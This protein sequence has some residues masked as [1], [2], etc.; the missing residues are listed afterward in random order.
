[1]HAS[2]R[3]ARQ[4]SAILLWS[5]LAA[6]L[7]QSAIGF[8][9]SRYLKRTLG[10]APEV[11]VRLLTLGAYL[12]AGEGVWHDVRLAW[13]G[14]RIEFPGTLRVEEAELG[15]PL[16]PLIRVEKA[17]LSQIWTL[18]T[19]TVDAA[20]ISPLRPEWRLLKGPPGAPSSWVPKVPLNLEVSDLKVELAVT[21]LHGSLS[22][23]GREG[24]AAGVW[25]VAL[26]DPEGALAEGSGRWSGE[27]CM[28]EFRLSAAKRESIQGSLTWTNDRFTLRSEA[29]EG[30][31]VWLLD[32]QGTRGA[33]ARFV[34]WHSAPGVRPRMAVAGIRIPEPGGKGGLVIK[35]LGGDVPL[36]PL[37]VGQLGRLDDLLLRLDSTPADPNDPVRVACVSVDV[38]GRLVGPAGRFRG[39]VVAVLRQLGQGTTDLSMEGRAGKEEAGPGEDP[40][41]APALTCAVQGEWKESGDTSFSAKFQTGGG[42]LGVSV[43]RKG[44]L[45]M[46]EGQLAIGKGRLT[47]NGT[48]RGEEWRVAGQGRIAP[49]DPASAPFPLPPGPLEGRFSAE[50]RGAAWESADFTFRGRG[51]WQ[52]RLTG[53]LW[54]ATVRD[55]E[56]TGHGM[57]VKGIQ[58][59]L[60]GKTAEGSPGLAS[61]RAKLDAADVS[62]GTGGQD[63]RLSLQGSGSRS[64]HEWRVGAVL[65]FLDGQASCRIVGT[66]LLSGSYKVEGGDVSLLGGALK[67]DGVGASLHPFDAS[68]LDHWSGASA[69][70][71]GEPMAGVKGDLHFDGATDTFKM[72]GRCPHWGGEVSALLTLSSREQ[73]SVD[74][75]VQDVQAAPVPA[76]VRNWVDLPLSL[77]DGTISGGVLLPLPDVVQGLGLDLRFRDATV[78][79]GEGGHAFR[80]AD[81]AL[82]A[83]LRAGVFEAAPQPWTLD[84]GR[85]ALDMGLGVRNGATEVS[86][87]TARAPLGRLQSALTDFLPEYLVFGKVDGEGAVEGKAVIDRDGPFIQGQLTLFAAGFLSEDKSLRFKG[88]TGRLPLVIHL[89][90]ATQA[91]P[92]YPSVIP[93]SFAQTFDALAPK[94]GEPPP[95]HLERVRYSVFT[96]DDLD[97]YPRAAEGN[98]VLALAGGRIWEGLLRGEVGLSLGEDGLRYAGQVLLK[99]ASLSAF[100]EQSGAL[101]GFLSGNASAGIT[102]A[103]E[104]AGVAD[105]RALGEVWVDPAGKEERVIARE[106][107]I[108]MGG[109]Q[110]KRI[111][112][113]DTLAYDV[114]RLRCGLDQG[115]LTVY[116]LQLSHEANPVLALV[117]KDVSFEV[118]V[119]QR[120]SISVWQLINHI[121]GLVQRPEATGPVG[122]PKE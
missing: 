2:F 37:P 91:V 105:L 110:V 26:R 84:G 14:A 58:A 101:R 74:I 42:G 77:P 68:A 23:W 20:T 10:T 75:H 96:L 15:P 32:G 1:M 57:A 100:C 119:P 108:K 34:L 93:A 52:A 7:I 95:L 46:H 69:T 41:G 61:W 17:N 116:S 38:E 56:L 30:R 73:S 81:G 92:G 60:T 94:G 99:D 16:A 103:G 40:S 64:R 106:F 109:E 35:D 53:G 3:T 4:A 121:K 90:R 112:R 89:V 24:G 66:Q 44:D 122:K 111:L 72:S 87:T 22:V 39:G 71:F 13:S 83:T 79:L 25:S 104:G 9:L 78:V 31:D 48:Y 113:R 80:R 5:I 33:R 86:F 50:G 85:L 65:P 115:I 19:G 43:S 36:P 45:W 117:R 114:G 98:V 18:P 107:L 49:F 76:F 27:G 88:V 28:A 59:S 63:A 67:F 47:W 118:R 11:K 54:A 55:G 102:F 97:V 70:I 8:G 12:P 82:K 6:G 62:W 21:E 120:N 29:L 51:F